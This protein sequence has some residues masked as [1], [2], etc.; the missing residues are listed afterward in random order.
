M[1]AFRFTLQA[2]LDQCEQQERAALQAFARGRREHER[3]A[4][5]LKAAVAE[6]EAARQRQSREQS[7]G[8]RAVELGRFHAFFHT[9]EQRRREREAVLARADEQ[10]RAAEAQ[11]LLA[12]RRKEMMERCRERK[13][14]E[15]QLASRRV[16]QKLTDELAQACEPLLAVGGLAEGIP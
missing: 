16:E 2:V 8:C 6:M 15:H 4:E 13:R 1:K 11:L 3:A 12:R 9:L 5:A 14:Q 10:L 7:R